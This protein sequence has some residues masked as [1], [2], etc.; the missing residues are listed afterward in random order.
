MEFES[1]SLSSSL[2]GVSSVFFA[3]LEGL[4]VFSLSFSAALFFL[5]REG[6]GGR[7]ETTASLSEAELRRVRLRV[8]LSRIE[9]RYAIMEFCK[10]RNLVANHISLSPSTDLLTPGRRHA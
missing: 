5:G 6:E 9:I 3:L 8:V 4:A 7:S 1:L 2:G 10:I